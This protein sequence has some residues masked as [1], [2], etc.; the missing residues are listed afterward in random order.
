MEIK[1]G[2]FLSLKIN[3]C[4]NSE[5]FLFNFNFDFDSNIDFNFDIKNKNKNLN[6]LKNSINYSKKEKD[7]EKEKEKENLL[8]ENFK[9]LFYS[10]DYLLNILNKTESFCR[11]NIFFEKLSK[12]I[13]V[14]F[15][16]KILYFF[17]SF[18]S[19]KCKFL[20]FKKFV[21]NFPQI[22]SK[23]FFDIYISDEK[24]F[25]EFDYEK[26]AKEFI[27]KFFIIFL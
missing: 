14:G 13:T 21:I 18:I 10:L 27:G 23:D 22:I 11:L 20:D 16:E 25:K 12:K 19:I 26:N 15:L 1:Q 5:I 6:E 8:P 4:I 9:K 7:E 3:E 2:G 24:N 17:Y